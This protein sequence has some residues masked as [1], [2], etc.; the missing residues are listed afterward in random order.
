MTPFA[1]I[2]ISLTS[3]ACARISVLCSRTTRT[4]KRV[5][6]SG[7]FVSYKAIINIESERFTECTCVCS[8]ASAMQGVQVF[9]SSLDEDAE[10]L[11]DDFLLYVTRLAESMT[12]RHEQEE[13][14]IMNA[15]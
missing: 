9:N 4:S 11:R 7:T 6:V 1:G 12:K 5:T 10:Q 14:N 13:L 2:I 8:P 3:K 15:R